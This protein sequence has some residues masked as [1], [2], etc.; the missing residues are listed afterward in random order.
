MDP[1][2]ELLEPNGVVHGGQVDKSGY[3]K[4][5]IDNIFPQILKRT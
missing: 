3:A 5:Y 4:L 2:N 1:G